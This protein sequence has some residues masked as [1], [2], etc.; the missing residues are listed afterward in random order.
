M[1]KTIFDVGAH[2]GEDTAFYLLKGFRVIA[3]EANPA[4][5][6]IITERF[7][8]DAVAGKLVVLNTAISDKCGTID[9]F[10]NNDISVWGT[11]KTDWV[12]RNRSLGASSVTKLTIGCQPLSKV[13]EDYGLPHYCKI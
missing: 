7:S 5:C 13:V 4:F 6:K 8:E 9:F 12:E 10:I 1:P 11:T 3:I 2:K